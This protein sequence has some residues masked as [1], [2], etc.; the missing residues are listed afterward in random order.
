MYSDMTKMP[1]MTVSC[2]YKFL[3]FVII[4]GDYYG[5][6]ISFTTSLTTNDFIKH[7]WIF[8]MS[9]KMADEI[10]GNITVLSL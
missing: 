7:L 6:P 9:A 5:M 1:Q 10:S 3:N 8:M 4:L 2:I